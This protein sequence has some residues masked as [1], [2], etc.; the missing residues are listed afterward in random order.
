VSFRALTNVSA[1]E[2][3]RALSQGAFARE[4]NTWIAQRFDLPPPDLPDLC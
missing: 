3:D 1:I 4:L 2:R